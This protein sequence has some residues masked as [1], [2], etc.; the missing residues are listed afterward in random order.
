[1]GQD[2]MK[3]D[4]FLRQYY[5][6]EIEDYG[7]IA[8]PEYKEFERN[9]KSVLKEIAKE[10][11]FT[12]YKFNGNHYEFSCVMQNNVTGNFYYISISDVR[13][14]NNEWANNILYRTMANDHDWTGGMN[15]YSTLKNLAE[16]LVNLYK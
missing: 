6:K 11:N 13:F 7:G 12:L 10:I 2:F 8:S 14:W 15:H 4:S 5:D 16:N 9:Y 1:M 3:I